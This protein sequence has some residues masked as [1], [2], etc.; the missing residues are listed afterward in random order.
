MD[1]GVGAQVDNVEALRLQDRRRAQGGQDVGITCRRTADGGWC[2]LGAWWDQHAQ[3]ADRRQYNLSGSM[4]QE[5]AAVLLD[6]DFT[7]KS[8]RCM[9]W[10]I[11]DLGDTTTIE[12]H[13]KDHA[14]GRIGF[15]FPEIVAEYQAFVVVGCV[16]IQ[17][18][19]CC[20]GYILATTI[21]K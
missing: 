18:G 7:D 21:V 17:Q 15:A 5:N 16:H 10:S 19:Y 20:K 8:H 2:C 6:P 3:A 13:R 14:S 11:D 9:Q 12:E 1:W 4:L